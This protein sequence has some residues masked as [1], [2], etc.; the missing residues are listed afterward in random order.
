MK[1]KFNQIKITG[2]FALAVFCLGSNFNV[3]TAA[4][5]SPRKRISVTTP[6][7][8]ATP[9]I[10]TPTVSPSPAPTA[11]PVPI[12]TLPE[13]QTQI[14]RTLARPEIRRGQTGVKIVSLDTGKTI[15][16]ENAEKY[17]MPASNM[18]SFTVAAALEKLSPDFRFVTSV[19]APA[20]PDA[21]GTI[22]GDVTVYG[23]GDVSI[24]FDFFDKDYSKGIDN[25]A[26]AMTLAGL[27]K[28]E[29]NL[30]GDDSYFSGSPIPAGWEWDDLQWNSGAE[31]S[32]LTVNNNVIDLTVKPG[33]SAGAACAVRFLP[34]NPVVRI[35]NRCATAVS[36]TKR[37]LRIFKKLDQNII[38]ISGTISADDKG[39]NNVVTISRPAELFLALLRGSLIQKGVVITG[40][41]RVIGAKDKPD[42]S[43]VTM[44]PQVE[45][46]KLASPPLSFIAA[47]TMKPSQ[48]LYT[49]NIL[50][51]L[52]EQM[53]I[54]AAQSNAAV[55]AGVQPLPSP[56][57][58]PLLNPKFESA[59]AGIFVVRNFLREIGVAPDGIIQ[60]DGSGLS[61]HNLI[62]PAAATQLYTF[63]AKQS[64]Y[65]QVWRDSLT[66]A[67]VDGTLR[68]RFV[69]TAGAG[70]V[71]GKTGTIDQVSA[72]SGYVT[73]AAGEQL[74]FSIVVNGVAGGNL[75][76]SII[77]EIVVGLATFNG[78]T[79]E[80]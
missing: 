29:G 9:P 79:N 44:L 43:A 34:F 32:A 70:N 2:F 52:G 11:T 45:V 80:K 21:N 16:E 22:R 71:R 14:R 46:T 61:R 50:R 68:N 65:S 67:G 17:F 6:T 76:Q 33:A 39:F 13:L 77:D 4:Q 20:M 1:R 15:F 73:T 31:P 53:K 7:P 47:R 49:E 55:S 41:N 48:N 54:S 60:H 42:L 19:Y 36:G 69:G 30:I 78:K 38:E 3:S 72:L 62:T 35:I 28:I 24:S 63:M 18:K 8:T 5:D 27:K 74:V 66:I 56:A 12:Q 10:P 23:R 25:L 57:D 75:R 59:E 37:D 64:R 40:Q 58:N 26:T 51:A